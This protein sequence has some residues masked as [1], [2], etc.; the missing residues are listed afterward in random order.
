MTQSS[1]VT[2]PSQ[3]HA[4]HSPQSLHHVE[5]RSVPQGIHHYEHIAAPYPGV[6]VVDPSMMPPGYVIGQVATPRIEEPE[7]PLYVN[8]KQ[9]HRILKRRAA[10]ANLDAQNKLMQRGRKFMHESRHLHAMRRPRGPGGRFLTAAEIAAL[11]EPGNKASSDGEGGANDFNSSSSSSNSGHNDGNN[12]SHNI[13][14]IN[15]N[16]HS[17]SNSAHHHVNGQYQTSTTRPGIPLEAEQGHTSMSRTEGM[18]MANP[19]QS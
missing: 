16:H 14:Y 15:S 2:S 13:N 11:D 6:I 12:N 5:A 4:S 1:R 8:A 19:Y 10:R 7:E 3:E 17:A 9:Y 18:R